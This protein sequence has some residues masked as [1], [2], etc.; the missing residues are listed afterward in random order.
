VPSRASSTWRCVLLAWLVCAMT[1]V[2]PMAYARPQTNASSRQQRPFNPADQRPFRVSKGDIEV[3]FLD[4][5][6]C[7]QCKAAYQLTFEAADRGR[8]KTKRFTLSDGPSQVDKIQILDNSRAAILGQYQ[9][10]VGMVV[11]VDLNAGSVIDKWLCFDPSVSPGGSL[12]VYRKVYPVHFTEGVSSEYLVYQ[13]GRSPAENR[14]AMASVGD[15]TNV[16]I[17]VYPPGSTNVP[18]DNTRVEQAAEHQM[19]SSDFFWAGDVK[20]AF[21]DRAAGVNS[22]V[23]V[24]LSSGVDRPVITTKRLESDEILTSTGCREFRDRGRAQDAILVSNIEFL[25][26]AENRLRVHFSYSLPDCQGPASLEMY[27]R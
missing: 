7:H 13:I 6:R 25:D 21:A 12:I 1:L 9:S 2:D 23:I 5:Q 18:G 11:L 14:P 22:I 19:A 4:A 15:T 8:G 17:P 10:N 3:S 24:D 27:A 26:P 16:G 20:F